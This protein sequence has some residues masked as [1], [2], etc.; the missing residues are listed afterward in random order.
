MGEELTATNDDGARAAGYRMLRQLA[1]SPMAT[2][3]DSALL[4][5]LT[6]DSAVEATQ[7]E[8]EQ[9]VD[10]TQFVRGTEEETT[11]REGP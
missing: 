5:E 1:T 11:P 8:L 7:A 10:D 2:D 9:H 6:R 3:D 4:L